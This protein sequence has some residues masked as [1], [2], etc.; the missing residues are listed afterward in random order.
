MNTAMNVS[1]PTAHSIMDRAPTAFRLLGLLLS[2][3]LG[4]I[5]AGSAA[6]S[7]APSQSKPTNPNPV[8]VMAYYYIWYDETSWD[9]AKIDYPMLGRYSSDNRMVMEQHVRWA[10][11]AGIDGFIVSWKSTFKLDS[12]LQQLADV[13]NEQGIYLWVIYQGL[14]FNRQPLPVDRIEADLEYFVQQFAD[15]PAFA[16]YP[17][18]MVIWSGTWE[19]S[20][21]EIDLVTARFR[22]RLTILASER[23]VNGYERLAASV[24]GN[25]YYWSSVNPATYPGYDEKLQALGAAVHDN[26]GYWVAPAAPGFDATL[27]GGTTIVDRSDGATFRREMDAALGSQPDAIG[28]I[29]WNEFSENTQIEPSVAYHRKSL[30][31]LAGIESSTAP[32]ILDFDS[33]APATIDRKQPQGLIVLGGFGIFVGFTMLIVVRRQSARQP[34]RQEPGV[35]P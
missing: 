7:V 12:R 21:A 11:D 5:L 27:L 10:K 25:A 28:V 18:P 16:M 6:A 2:V 19:F 3:S 17:K 8:P 22:D 1:K 24:D 30:D 33:N 13:A 4:L 15:H 34:D 9:R 31:I 14:D 23:N 29:S 20:P 32:A 35:I 26:G